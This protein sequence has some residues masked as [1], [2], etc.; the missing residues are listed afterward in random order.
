MKGFLVA[1]ASFGPGKVADVTAA[2]LTVAFAGR[3]DGTMSF[4]RASL[5]HVLHRTSLAPNDLAFG[6]QGL[7]IVQSSF[8]AGDLRDARRYVVRYEDG[9]TETASEVDLT[10]VESSRAATPL[11]ALGRHAAGPYVA[12]AARER[13]SAALARQA[14]QVGGLRALLSSRVDLHA[15]Q[16]FVAGTVILD[17]RRRYVLAD[18]VGLGK[19]VEAGVVIHDVLSRRPRA[20]VLVLAPGPLVRQWLTEMAASF[21]GQDFRLADLHAPEAV[22]IDRWPRLIVSTGLATGHLREALL[23]AHWDMVVIDEAHH[24]VDQPILH[25][26]ARRLA[27]DT[28]D[29]LLLSAIPARRRE[30]EFLRLLALLE[31]ARYGEDA[32]GEGASEARAR[33]VELHSAQEV[34]GRRVGRLTA[35]MDGLR[36]GD[37]SPADVLDKAER[38]AGLPLVRDDAA[39]GAALSALRAGAGPDAPAPDV[40]EAA[41]ALRTA[42]VDRFRIHRRILRNRRQRLVADDRLASV[43]RLSEDRPY[44]PDQIELEAIQAVEELVGRAAGRGVPT[45]TGRLMA[46]TLF[47]ALAFPAGIHDLLQEIARDGADEPVAD[48]EMETLGAALGPGYAAWPSLAAALRQGV[49]PFLDGDV[50]GRAV[51]T[52]AAWARSGGSRGRERALSDAVR[53]ILASG[54]GKVLVFAGYPGLAAASAD[55]L[56]RTLG[57]PVP[58][59]THDMADADKEET[60]RLFRAEQRVRVLVCD[61]SGGEGRNFQFA[62]AI[63]HAD[64]PWQVGLVEQRIGRL[65]RLGRINPDIPSHVV[66]NSAAAEA[67]L[68]DCYGAAGLGVLVRSVS[69]AEFALRALQDAIV[70]AAVSGC[71][72]GTA[73]DA[74]RTLAPSLRRAVEEERARD[75]GE[76]ILDEASFQEDAAA[77]FL[78]SPDESVETEIEEAFVA[79][80]RQVATPRSVAHHG[81]DRTPR[82]IWRFNADDVREGGLPDLRRTADGSAAARRI[83][84]FRR[85]IARARRD[86]EF[87]APGNP[88]FDAVAASLPARTAGRTYAIGILVPGESPDVVAEFA[89]ILR[90][91]LRR[92]SGHPGL[93]NQAEAVVGAR[94]RSVV[95]PLGGLK[96]VAEGPFLGLKARC[97]PDRKGR[98]WD[99]LPEGTLARLAASVPDWPDYLA[100]AQERARLYV[101]A[102]L[103]PR[104]GPL[105]AAE[106]ARV[107]DQMDRIKA[108]AGPSGPDDSAREELDGLERYRRAVAGW[109]VF[110][111]AVGVIAV[112][113]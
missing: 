70:D 83:G 14:V 57:E 50:L 106:D 32:D 101:R 19:T 47:Q 66:V 96:A 75:E 62:D 2:G 68:P 107:L 36:T 45:E 21:G 105:V 53:D 41:K 42:V 25:G 91:D 11:G 112:N 73:A 90:P 46:R 27:A 100:K 111:D 35:E 67:G 39:V 71:A 103:Q 44:R 15:H 51:R 16:A 1:H 10:P 56:R 92:L 69:G 60:A 40:V 89:M 48:H 13:L 33:F 20:R 85:S 18:E 58:A 38:L 29:L 84:T 109:D 63:V 59:F 5:G 3:G 110:L 49:R 94:R 78:K 82:G 9:L 65:D 93:A 22:Q 99:D 37:A 24:L 113:P 8:P 88:F 104:L 76:A 98:T 12:F 97:T 95:F 64:L 61:E 102:S 23:D 28:R 31:P 34:I 52:A 43:R 26:V 79:H 4:A 108:E 77:R 74:M 30:T 87:F 81:D 6:P 86:V 72:D 54:K 80:F 7:C 17:P 55:T